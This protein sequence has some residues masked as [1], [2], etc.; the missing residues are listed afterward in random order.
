LLA[1]LPLRDYQQ[2]LPDLGTV[3]LRPKRVLLRPDTATQK[4]YFLEG[5][6][7]SLAAATADGQTAGVAVVGNEGAVVLSGFGDDGSITATVEIVD[8]DAQVMDLAAFRRERARGAA[9]TISSSATP[10]LSRPV[11]CNRS[12][13][14]PRTL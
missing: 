12:H 7:C 8:G 10:Q 6:V 9:F 5:G 3:R 2:L 11:S 1:R 4:V 14:T 13:A